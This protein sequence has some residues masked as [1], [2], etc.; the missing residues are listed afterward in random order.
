[1]RKRSE[2]PESPEELRE[3]IIGF[4]ENSGRKS[5]YPELRERLFTLERFRSLLDQTHDAIFVT[6]VAGERVADVNQAACRMLE[7]TRQQLM[8]L[9]IREISPAL[10][11]LIAEAR[12][13]QVVTSLCGRSGH[14]V[15]VE[16]TVAIGGGAA[17][18][19]AVI[20]ARDV[21]ERTRAE[22]AVERSRQ[23]LARLAE[24]SLSVMSRTDPEGLLQGLS[25]AAL[26][27]TG[28]RMTA[29]GHGLLTG[30]PLLIGSARA[31][32]VP[33]SPPGMLFQVIKGGVYMELLEGAE[34]IRLTDEQLRAHP[35]W[36]GL[37]ERHAPIRGLLG[38]RLLGRSGRSVGMILATDKE[39]GDFSEEDESLLKQL[40]TVA[41]LALQHV[42]ARISL[43]EA[44][45]RKNQFL[46]VLSHELRNPLAPI[47]N[48]LYV[49]DRAEPGGEQARRAQAV[50]DR[51]VAHMTR[52][53]DDLLDVTRISRGKIQLQRETLDF[54]DVTR[55]AAEDHLSAFLASGVELE[56]A[57]P[58]SP[59]R[60][61]GDRTRVAQVMGNL[62]Q[63]AWRFTPSGG[64]VS[65]SVEVDE[66]P[67]QAIA[68]VRDTGAGIAPE[69]LPRLFE[70]FMQADTTL[71]RSKG[72]L[73]LGLALV[74]GLV[75]MHGGTVSVESEGLG[76]GAEFAVRF[77][78]EAAQ[79]VADAPRSLVPVGGARRVLV[80]ED[81]VDAAESLREVLEFGGHLVEVAHTGAAGI[82]GARA[83]RPDVIL[84]DIGLPGMDGYDVARTIRS[85]P[86]LRDTTL[87]ALTG[88]AAPDDVAKAREAGFDLHVAKPPSMQE[89]QQAVS[90]RNPERRAAS[91]PSAGP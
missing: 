17:G 61:N 54:A 30:Q 32:G 34:S 69:M 14:R 64:R 3:K 15:P 25:E 47:R 18:R 44:D 39:G 91:L 79:R 65:V 48:S 56:I 63:N 58:E 85:D 60:I 73:G 81:N 8:G 68:R 27:L 29:C 16:A 38:A 21:S 55:R 67:G 49:L 62:L 66:T 75:E 45:R 50:I 9:S 7:C 1:M 71:D 83:F 86:Q 59:V 88:Y 84:C 4:G 51:Q 36:W 53:V 76:R 46:A 24:A 11:D 89:I 41:S 90:L 52:L 57:S 22:Q 77:P 80:I 19:D 6:E 40:A 37:P 23:G 35:R 10:A 42:E 78:L 87:V 28:A 70:P 5:F 31:P 20:V 82:E 2:P 12:N 33:V 26:A 13:G 43:E 74:K 72:G